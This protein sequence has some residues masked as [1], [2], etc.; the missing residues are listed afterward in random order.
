MSQKLN[1]TNVFFV[2]FLIDCIFAMLQVSSVGRL[3]PPFALTMPLGFV[4]CGCCLLY[5]IKSGCYSRG[6]ILSATF[7]LILMLVGMIR[8]IFSVEG[9]WGYKG[10]VSCVHCALSFVLLFPFVSPSIASKSLQLWNRYIFPVFLLF[11]LWSLPTGSYP[12]HIPFIYYVYLLLI[13]IAL[14]NHKA[15]LIIIIG[16]IFTLIAVENRSALLKTAVAFALSVTLYLP[17]A[18]AKISYVFIHFLFYIIPL[19]LLVLG[20]TGTFNIFQDL[21]SDEPT[22]ITWSTTDLSEQEGTPKLD[23]DTRTFLYVD[24]ILSAIEG[25]YVLFGHSIGRG[26]TH[27]GVWNQDLEGMDSSERLMNEAHMLNIFTWL[28]ILGIILYT[29]MY[30]QSSCLGLFS[31]KNRY[32]PLIACAVAFHWAMLW[33]EECPSLK[34][35]DYALFLLLGMCFSPKFRRMTDAEF[36]LWFRSCFANPNELTAYDVL[37]RLMLQILLTKAKRMK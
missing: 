33:L 30:L 6:Y 10:W 25:D 21:S 7:V 16:T 11:G 27:S 28:G 1:V 9:Y 14:S 5:Y 37:K 26:N 12:F 18:I 2:A 20:L 13:P 34:P 22:E 32:V 8:G 35:L 15:C 36:K 29:I 4:I 3:H 23:A 31:S 17:R 24:V 19:I